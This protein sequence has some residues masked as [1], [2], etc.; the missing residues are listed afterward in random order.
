[1]P[2]KTRSTANEKKTRKRGESDPNEPPK[3]KTRKQGESDPNEPPKRQTRKRGESDPNKP[4]KRPKTRRSSNV[5]EVEE[6]GDDRGDRMVQHWAGKGKR[7]K[8]KCPV[9]VFLSSSF[10]FYFSL[11][12]INM[13]WFYII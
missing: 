10:F 5:S 2:R 13:K 11:I 7:A 6:A 12:F 9:C 1:M 3:R 4:P 8:K